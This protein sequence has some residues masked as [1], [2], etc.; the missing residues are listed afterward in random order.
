VALST[1]FG[2]GTR[3]IHDTTSDAHL[4]NKLCVAEEQKVKNVL[5]MS[6]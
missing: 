6:P 2:K 3:L 5:P 1:A 4:E